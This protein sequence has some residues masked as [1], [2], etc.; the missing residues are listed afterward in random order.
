MFRLSVRHRGKRTEKLKKNTQMPLLDPQR[1]LAV[2]I[3][4]W[5]CFTSELLGSEW[6]NNS[7]ELVNLQCGD[8]AV[9]VWK[10][11]ER[12]TC[13][14]GGEVW[15]MW[16]LLAQRSR[17]RRWRYVG[18]RG[19]KCWGVGVESTWNSHT[20]ELWIRPAAVNMFS[21][22]KRAL[23][24]EIKVIIITMAIIWSSYQQNQTGKERQGVGLLY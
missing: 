3:T 4:H 16:G 10:G 6:T 8:N 23:H 15:V 20:T 17:I 18:R 13:C 22:F 19:I 24:Q 11:L 12:L 1:Q 9:T 2:W 14:W 7:G 5:C 21:G